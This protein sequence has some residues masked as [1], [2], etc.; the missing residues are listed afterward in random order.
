MAITTRFGGKLVEPYVT[1]LER[2][3][4]QVRVVEGQ[5]G[6]EDFC[7]LLSAQKE[8]VGTYKST[9][10]R[11]AAFLGEAKRANL[12][13]LFT[14]GNKGSNSDYSPFNWT[15]PDLKDRV[16]HEAFKSE[17]QEALEARQ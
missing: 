10:V 6:T 9:Y 5:S 2:R 7:F 12:Y 14:P 16:F 8:L 17:E 13:E 11:W 4:L 15:H 3:G 1:A